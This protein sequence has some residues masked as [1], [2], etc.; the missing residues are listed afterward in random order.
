M[1][2]DE[3]VFVDT[4]VLLYTLDMTD[5]SRAAAA[6]RWMD[7]LWSSGRGCLSW[8]VLNEFYANAVRKLK[9]PERTAR[10]VIETLAAWEM[11]HFS[12]PLARRAWRWCDAAGLS[13]WDALIL[14]AA[15]D[16]GCRWLL[17]EDFQHGRTYGS[18]R[19]INPFQTDPASFSTAVPF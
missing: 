17:S 19:A 15:E 8:Q 13:Y 5:R 2:G 4:N 1:T 7:I 16:R 9:T 6:S 12:L 10:S 3:P 11:A 18:V 14:A